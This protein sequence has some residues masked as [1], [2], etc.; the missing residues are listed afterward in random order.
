MAQEATLVQTKSTLGIWRVEPIDTNAYFFQTDVN[1]NFDIIDVTYTK[2][3]TSTTI[4]AVMNPIDVIPNP[5]PPIITTPD[6]NDEF[7]QYGVEM[8]AALATVE[9]IATIINK[10][11][12]KV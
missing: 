6:S 10:G 12:N 2:G 1:L 7:W 9:I 5:T 4:A 11:T 3:K 8:I